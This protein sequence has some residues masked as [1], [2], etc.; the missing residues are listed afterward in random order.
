[1]SDLA[2]LDDNQYSSLY[3]FATEMRHVEVRADSAATAEAAAFI[4]REARVLDDGGYKLWLTMFTDD[5][6]YW[7]PS[8]I[9]IE[10]P[11]RSV[12]YLLDDR[13][14]LEDRIALLDTGWAHAQIPPSVTQRVIANVEGWYEG[15]N[16]VHARAGAVIWDHRRDTL[17]PTPAT[18]LYR[19]VRE[20]TQSEW[21]ISI[22]IVHR[23]AAAGAI[24][25]L[26]FVL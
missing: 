18:M 14:R 16:R 22:R 13:R 7:V 11:R 17:T 9:P 5:C 3:H 25:N 6:I 1:M 20:S 10:D 12:S 8:S 4:I 26:A 15:E 21:R 19:L 24:S 23:L 2:V